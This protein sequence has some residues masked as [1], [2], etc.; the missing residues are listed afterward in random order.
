[1]ATGLIYQ[2]QFKDVKD[3]L[4]R[5]DIYD[6]QAPE[7]DT[8]RYVQLEA[9]AD[10][11]QLSTIDNDEDKFT[12]IRSQQLTMSFVSDQGLGLEQF[13]DGPDDRF[14]VESFYNGQIIFRGFLSL[15]DN[16]EAFLPPR[17][18]VTLTASDKLGTLKD[19]PLVDADG[20]N[21]QGKYRIAEILTMC[22]NLTGQ[23]LNLNVVHNLKPVIN[24][25]TSDDPFYDVCY[26]DVK[27]FEAEIGESEDAYSV[28]EKILGYDSSLFYWQGSWWIVRTDERELDTLRWAT[29][30][31][32]G[33]F[34]GYI[35]GSFNLSV[36]FNEPTW[37]AN[38]AT[39]WRPSREVGEVKLTL[40][41]E[42]PEELV[43]NQDFSRGTPEP[44]PTVGD[45]TFE[46]EPECIEYLREG[47]PSTFNALDQP[48]F[49]G[50][51]GVL[52]KKFEGGL[53]KESYLHAEIAGGFRHYFKMRPLE[54]GAK[55]KVAIAFNF[56]TNGD[57]SVTN[58]YPA[59]VLL[60]GDDGTLWEWIH[61]QPAQTGDWVLRTGT[62]AAFAG[63]W[64][65]DLSGLDASEWQGLSDTSKPIPVA[66][67]LFIRLV[68]ANNG[69]A[70]E[71]SDLS[72]EYIPFI[73]GSYPKYTGQSNTVKRNA[74]GYLNRIDES[75]FIG[76]APVKAM[77]GGI[78]TLNDNGR[79]DLISQFSYN[80]VVNTFGW[81]QAQAVWNQHRN[82]VRVFEYE[83]SIDPSYAIPHLIHRYQITDITGATRD[84]YF[85]MITF[86]TDL[87]LNEMRGTMPEVY[88]TD[89]GKLYTDPFTFKYVTK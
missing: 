86:E 61:D 66:G 80:G 82:A 22:L 30:G 72:I 3:G 14:L 75:V 13:A 23:A 32:D 40:D 12:P 10:P 81:H 21:P 19:T 29:F 11:L 56:R 16:S 27:T 57:N 1:M 78:F 70:L 42:Y 15:A 50:S 26:L 9:A 33:A 38:A 24:G 46:L 6:R 44:T 85:I 79:F 41:Y 76:D 74:S 49:A 31:P 4:S 28:I 35:E 87:R 60:Q 45:E 25:I 55:D 5:T 20:K 54:V 37:F 18:V 65:A 64:H 68:H 17:N 71:F 52:I 88:R 43:C 89:L 83:V 34:N 7:A 62:D 48:A 58:Q 39:Q 69:Y 47:G 67:Q 59:L 8:T 73:N 84:R 53:E 51:K 2:L 77:K 63:G 36:G